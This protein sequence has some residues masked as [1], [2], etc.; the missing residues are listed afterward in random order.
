MLNDPST[1]PIIQQLELVR[2]GI[3]S[4]EQ[5][6]PILPDFSTM[7]SI[8]MYATGGLTGPVQ[9]TTNFYQTSTEDTRL[10]ETV[11]GLRDEIRIMNTYLSDPRNRQAYISND[12]LIQNEKEMNLLNYL[13]QL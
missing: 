2:S 8:P 7:T 13:K 3:L 11:Q 5:L 1:G 6:R 4:P 9:N 10:L 12:V